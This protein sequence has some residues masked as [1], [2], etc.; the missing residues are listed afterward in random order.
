MIQVSIMVK[1]AVHWGKRNA[2]LH[3]TMKIDCQAQVGEA[4]GAFSQLRPQRS[5]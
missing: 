4:C 3:K 2:E 1:F 5:N